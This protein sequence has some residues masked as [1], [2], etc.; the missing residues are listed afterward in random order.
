MSNRTILGLVPALAAVA[1][2]GC[3]TICSPGPDPVD[4]GSKPQGAELIVNGRSMGYTPVMLE[5]RPEKTYSVT[6]RKDGYEPVT[7]T[8][9]SHVQAGWVVL[10]IFAGVVGVAIDAATGKWKA[11]D[12]RHQFV[13]LREVDDV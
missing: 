12:D 5:L 3:A 1:L 8:L 11:F 9:T 2:L 4:F 13:V 7:V 6:F 10:D